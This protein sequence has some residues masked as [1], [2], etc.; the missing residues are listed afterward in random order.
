MKCSIFV[1]MFLCFLSTTLSQVIP[2]IS[3]KAQ[4]DLVNYINRR[5]KNI[6]ISVHN[7]PCFEVFYSLFNNST[8]K[9]KNQAEIC[10]KT[11][12]SELKTIM[13]VE[14][15]EYEKIVEK[16]KSLLENCGSVDDFD[17]F[18]CMTDIAEEVDAYFEQIEEMYAELVKKHSKEI[19]KIN[20]KQLKCLEKVIKKLKRENDEIYEN[21]KQCQG[22]STDEIHN[23][24]QDDTDEEPDSEDKND[25]KE[26]SQ[27]KNTPI[28]IGV[29]VIVFGVCFCVVFVSAV[30]YK[31]NNYG[32]VMTL[33]TQS[34]I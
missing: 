10:Q 23:E 15:E 28:V 27:N 18:Q 30:V 29:T 5:N 6:P 25:G 2:H 19:K 3:V 21:L 17:Y 14:N 8:N 33:E 7:S 12:L 32:K 22:S 24:N 4:S 20:Y 26:Y 1:A 13:Q 31:T 34:E 16:I 11:A 9:A